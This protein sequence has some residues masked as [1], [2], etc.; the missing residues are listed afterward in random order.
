VFTLMLAC[1]AGLA[2]CDTGAGDGAGTEGVRRGGT[3]VIA[4]GTDLR[5][6]NAL[7]ESEANTSEILRYA[8]FLPLIR[9]DEDLGFQPALARSWEWD[10]DTAVVF[11]LRDDVRW[12]DGRP[13]TAEDVKFTFDRARDPATGFPNAEYF[14]NWDGAE[15]LDSTTVRFSLRPHADPLAVLPATP[16]MPRHLL[17]S[18]PAEQ[19]QNAPFNQEPVG[20]G[21]FRFVSRRANDRVVLEANPDFPEELGGRPAVDRVVWQVIPENS[22]QLVALRTGEADVALGIRADQVEALDST[23]RFHAV[24]AP[25]RTYQFI[26]WNGKVPALSDARVRRALVM[27][28]DRE[29]MLRSLRGGFGE[30]T[31]T[32]VGPSHWAHDPS[33]EPLPFDTAAAREL[34]AEAGYENRDAD[35]WL[36]DGE[37]NELEI[38][39]KIPANNEYNR[40]LAELIRGDGPFQLASYSNPELDGILDSLSVTVDRD[41]ARPLWQRLQQI[42][43]DEQPWGYLWFAP[44]LVVVRDDVQGVDMDVRGTFVSLPEWWLESGHPRAGAA[45]DQTA[46][47]SDAS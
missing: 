1:V 34:F 41:R 28:L 40:D 12:H 27:A 46:S 18:I 6:F 30:L 19:L 16:I 38:E 5:S 44:R 20:N 22:A 39:L 33:I 32:P 36:E 37:G 45:P 8:L 11:R 47:P 10:G 23:G 24:V 9:Y 17:D 21:P 31:A 2:G 13:T 26:G 3:V 7:V 4:A 42:L 35:P 14:E 25:S 29:A 15:V 43:H